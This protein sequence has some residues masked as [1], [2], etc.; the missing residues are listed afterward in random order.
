VKGTAIIFFVLSTV[1][2]LWPR[3]QDIWDRFDAEYGSYLALVSAVGF[4]AWGFYLVVTR[5][6]EDLF[7]VISFGAGVLS[8]LGFLWS[9]FVTNDADQPL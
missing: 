8:I 4:F 6:D 9:R 2:Y 5:S 3:S 7:L 1:R